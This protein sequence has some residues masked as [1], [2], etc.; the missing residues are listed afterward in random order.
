LVLFGIGDGC[1]LLLRLAL[2]FFISQP[3][4]MSMLAV[5]IVRPTASIELGLN[6]S[7][8]LTLLLVGRVDASK[9]N[10]DHSFISHK[11]SQESKVGYWQF[12]LQQSTSVSK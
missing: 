12:G 3:V 6:S 5:M 7:F 1:P 11:D 4:K 2:L 10:I 9:S 8:R